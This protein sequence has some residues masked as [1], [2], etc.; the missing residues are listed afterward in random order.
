MTLRMQKN[1]FKACVAHCRYDRRKDK[2]TGRK[3]G[4]KKKISIGPKWMQSSTGSDIVPLAPTLADWGKREEGED[5]D[6]QRLTMEGFW[7]LLIRQQTVLEEA[8]VVGTVAEV[9]G[10][11]PV[12]S[13]RGNPLKGRLSGTPPQRRDY[14]EP[15]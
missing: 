4:R 5:T 7:E 11:G 12:Y 2:C 14:M 8:E 13:Q 1:A 10:H 3:P 15:V 9:M 6:L